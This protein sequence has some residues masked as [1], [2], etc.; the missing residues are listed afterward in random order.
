MRL[1]RVRQLCATG[2]GRRIREGGR[3]SLGEVARA[4]GT[5]ATTVWRWEHLE[6]TPR[7]ELA[8]QYLQLLE[9]LDA[10]AKS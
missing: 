8:L 9:Q 5:S 4:I 3:L 7:G 1:A 2:E 10:E 6:R